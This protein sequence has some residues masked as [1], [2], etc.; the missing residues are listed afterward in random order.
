MVCTCA[1]ATF[2]DHVI[3]ITDKGWMAW[4]PAHPQRRPRTQRALMVVQ[5]GG[6]RPGKPVQVPG[7][8]PLGR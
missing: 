1:A 2:E 5:I 6:R 4:T 8:G 7:P 3:V